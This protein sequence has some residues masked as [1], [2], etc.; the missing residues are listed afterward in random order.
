MHVSWLL[1]GRRM[2]PIERSSQHERNMR[3][4][5]SQSCKRRLSL[6]AGTQTHIVLNGILQPILVLLL[7][8][9]PW[10]IDGV[11]GSGASGSEP[12]NTGITKFGLYMLRSP[13][14][15][16]APIGDEVMF[17]C[18]LNLS[19]ERIV[20]RFRHLNATGRS[21]ADDFKLIDNSM[22]CSLIHFWHERRQI[23]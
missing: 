15:T 10:T 5:Q 14:S 3:G 2:L 11:D 21:R 9:A 1:G 18:A 7:L 23:F 13:E 4:S 22:V 12:L 16:V 19:P 8:V 6:E 20:W 17:E